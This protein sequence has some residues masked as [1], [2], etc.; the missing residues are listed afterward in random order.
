MEGKDEVVTQTE[1][2]TSSQGRLHLEEILVQ[3]QNGG[4]GYSL[5]A[6]LLVR[7]LL[8]VFINHCCLETLPTGRSYSDGRALPLLP[9]TDAAY[10]KCVALPCILPLM[11]GYTVA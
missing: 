8:C 5:Q 6:S 4:Q 11:V 2:A 10:I 1:G 7:L 3:C 9:C